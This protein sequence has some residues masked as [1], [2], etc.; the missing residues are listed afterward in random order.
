MPQWNPQQYLKFKAERTRPAQ[1]LVSRIRD[2]NPSR[3]LDLGCGPG[4]STAVLYRQFP[5]AQIIGADASEEMVREAQNTYPNLQFVKAEAPNGLTALG[6]FDLIFSNACIQWIPDHPRLL[7][8]LLALL[9]PGGTLAV[10]TPVNQDEP[11]HRIISEVAASEKWRSYFQ[12]PRIFY[13]LSEEEYYD[14]L[15]EI[16]SGFEMWQ[17]VYCHQLPSREAILEWYRGTG[18][19]PYLEQLPEEKKAPFEREIMERLIDAYPLRRGNSVLFRFP[20]LFFTASPKSQQRT[21][22]ICL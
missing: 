11:I 3:I 2:S 18:L 21:D 17:T 7:K 9:N 8:T 20:R 22:K 10:Q 1:D 14:L 12:A 19:R 5:K 13:N 15:T 16:S 6:S 4:N